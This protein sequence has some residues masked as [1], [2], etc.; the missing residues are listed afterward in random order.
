MPL[1]SVNCRTSTHPNIP[2]SISTGFKPAN[3]AN[4][5]ADACPPKPNGKKQ[6]AEPTDASIPGALPQTPTAPTTST[7]AIP[8]TTA[9]HLLHI[10]GKAIATGAVP[11]AYWTWLAMFGNGHRTNTTARTINAAHAITP[12][13]MNSEPTSCTSNASYAA[14][15][16]SARLS[17]FAQQ[18]VTLDY[19]TSKPIHLDF[20]VW[21]SGNFEWDNI[22][23]LVE[24]AGDN[25]TFFIFVLPSATYFFSAA[26]KSRQKMPLSN[27]EG[28]G[29]AQTACVQI[30]KKVAYCIG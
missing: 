11:T 24:S 30:Q 4:G 3:T 16:G 7:A 17:S 2:L 9:Q 6:R 18:R 8:L 21:W 19:P 29:T 10:I 23:L 15:P 27:A 25:F 20:G 22:A 5:L 28:L 14:G 1:P 13:T 26:K 12:S